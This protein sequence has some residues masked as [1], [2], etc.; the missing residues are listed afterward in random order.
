MP[1]RVLVSGFASPHTGPSLFA[2]A[3][4]EGVVQMP[5]MLQRAFPLLLLSSALAANE[6]FPRILTIKSKLD[7]GIEQFRSSCQLH[8]NK[9]ALERQGRIDVPVGGKL[10]VRLYGE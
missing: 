4:R 3:R 5:N 8:T 10:F 7:G 1:A 9:Q 2:L 6:P